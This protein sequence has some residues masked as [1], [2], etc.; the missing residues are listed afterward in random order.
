MLDGQRAGRILDQKKPVPAPGDVAGD[1]AGA[2]QLDEDILQ[3]PVTLDILDRGL[4]GRQQ[5]HRDHADRRVE[6]MASGLDPAEM[7]GGDGGADGRMAAHA[8]IADGVEI[9]DAGHAV[10]RRRRHQERADHRIMTARFQQNAA[11]KIT[12]H[13]LEAG[14]ALGE[15]TAPELGATLE[16]DACRLAFGMRIDYA[17][18]ETTPG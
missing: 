10:R 12:M 17:H 7:R 15:R 3:V 14:G 5:I 1:R 4:V 2:I 18:A 13:A 8:E 16:D 9:D 11:L 6:A